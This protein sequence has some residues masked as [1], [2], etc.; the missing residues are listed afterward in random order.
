MADT[1]GVKTGFDEHERL[2]GFLDT[3]AV[4]LGCFQT[5]NGQLPDSTRPDVLRVNTKSGFLFIGDAKNT[6]IP[7]SIN[8]QERLS[9]YIL[10]I[11]PFVSNDNNRKLM[12]AI[13]HNKKENIFSWTNM[14]FKLFC[15]TGIVPFKSGV[16]EFDPNTYIEWLQVN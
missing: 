8:T 11:L 9:K 13:C 2:V 15:Q 12:F 14:L 10:W 5:L 4:M 3:M 6:E 16:E 7:S 1:F